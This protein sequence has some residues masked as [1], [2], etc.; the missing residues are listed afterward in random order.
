MKE[1][2]FYILFFIFSISAFTQERQITAYRTNEEIK[3]DGLIN[4]EAWSKAECTGDFV[5]Y[6][7]YQGQMPYKPTKVCVLYDDRALYIGAILYDDEPDKIL[8]ELTMRDQ[9]NGNTDMFILQL[10]PYN[11]KRNVYEFKVTAANVQTDIMISDGNYDY[12]W[13]AVWQSGV[14]IHE[15]KWT[16]E[17][18]IPY[19]AI[20][21]PN[22]PE[23]SWSANF[24]RVIRRNR[25]YSCWNP[26][27]QEL[28]PDI[29]Q[30]GKIIGIRDIKPPIRL[31][32]YP[33]ISTN[34]DFYTSAKKPVYGLSGGLDMK[35]G[36]TK[37][38][39]L[40][41]TLV[42]DFSHIKSDEEELNLGPF[43]TYYSE[44][45]PF[46]TEGVELFEK[47]GLFYSR[48]IGKIPAK[49]DEIRSMKDDNYV[50][51]D[52]PRYAR[53]INAIKLSGRNEKK[54]GIG[55]F[56]AITANTWAEVKDSAGNIHK[57]L[58]EPWANYN[59]VVL[60]QSFWHNSY[61]NLTNAFVIRPD[62]NYLSNVIGTAFKFMDPSNR[63]GLYGKAAWS[64][65]N[66]SIG[67][68]DL[69][70]GFMINSGLGK[71]NGKWQYVY[72]LNLLSDRYNPNDFGYLQQNN[73][74]T[75]H[76]SLSYNIFQPFG[77]F[78]KMSIYTDLD[79]HRL[80]KSNDL[81]QTKLL[82]NAYLETNKFFSTW[83]YLD[84]SLSDH[85]DYFE[86][87]APGRLYRRPAIQSTYI[88]LSTDY[89][90][91]FA[92]D[93]RIGAYLDFIKR[94]GWWGLIKPRVRISDKITLIYGLDFD[95]DHNDCGFV[96]DT[97]YNDEIIFGL[98][99]VNTITNSLEG[100]WVLNNKMYFNLTI[101]NYWRT[102]DY[103]EF[104]FLNQD[105]SLSI[106][107]NYA[108][109]HD[110]N[111]N[112]F[113]V[114]FMF[115]WNFAPGSYMNIMWKNQ[116]FSNEIIHYYTKMPS[117]NENLSNLFKNDQTNSISLR[118]IYYFDWQY[119]KKN[120]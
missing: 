102:V 99:N 60:D 26:V 37:S 41:L 98:R 71:L 73:I 50:I 43:E 55:V 36:I 40:D 6:K 12:N 86:A 48:R 75:H 76:L 101:R 59:M 13:D 18:A 25:E 107:N 17:I 3:I 11:D 29:E 33:Y 58:T 16:V 52:N 19:S 95:F 119:L 44:Y 7:P 64:C 45:R 113:N 5:T 85:Y 89:R 116:I 80:F 105:G 56:N 57:I 70:N 42:P 97:I 4:E 66:D 112:A 62:I 110:I 96:N 30:M 103:S 28:G 74:I 32:F 81:V 20:R 68:N 39:T 54:L 88:Y 92:L 9:D 115:S 14:T 2:I 38:H 31:A 67:N 15:N 65:I 108:Q 24:W 109:D 34:I 10:N 84:F 72:E 114:D 69:D 61:V 78:N 93:F 118:L 100:R 77:K 53:L 87:R 23:Q 35:L 8:K 51:I 90:K 94:N 117:F 79:H 83:I 82:L 49:Y 1:Y 104:Y 106:I 63:F 47:V 27:K 91:V 46:F 22:I 120:T 21:F 111:F